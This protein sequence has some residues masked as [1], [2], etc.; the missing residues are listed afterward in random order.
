[1]VMGMGLKTNTGDDLLVQCNQLIR[2]SRWSQN[3]EICEEECDVF[4]WSEV[5]VWSLGGESS[6]V[7]GGGVVDWRL[8]TQVKDVLLGQGI[9]PSEFIRLHRDIEW[10]SEGVG[11][12]SHLKSPS[13]IR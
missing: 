7:S 2:D 8:P 13:L 5:D 1:M 12:H 11:H 6:K 10:S 3:S 9:H 4:S